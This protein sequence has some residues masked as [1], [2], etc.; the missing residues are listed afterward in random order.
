MTTE[1]DIPGHAINSCDALLVACLQSDYI[2]AMHTL[3]Y[4]SLRLCMTYCMQQ[5]LLNAVTY[6]RMY[7]MHRPTKEREGYAMGRVVRS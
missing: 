6:A 2:S 7:W 1:S 4:N 5:Y 3:G